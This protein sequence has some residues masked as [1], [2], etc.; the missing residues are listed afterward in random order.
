MAD[1]IQLQ[2]SASAANLYALVRNSAGD[3][4]NGA[5]FVT[6]A[7]ADLGSYDLPM[8]EQATSKFYAVA[9]PTVAAGV[10]AV[11]AY[12]RAGG[13]PAESDSCI[14]SGDVEWSGTAMI[15]T[16]SQASV[17]SIDGR[18]P[19]ALIG[20]RIDAT[21]DATGMEAG[22]IDAIMDDTIGDGTLT[23]RQALRVLVAGMAGKLSGAATSTVTIRNTADS[24]DVIVASVDADG[25]R[26]AVTVNV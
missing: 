16:A 15:V 13:A 18:I 3:I 11:T 24:V 2:H 19:A 14:A 9:F 22:A 8:T 10:Y 1:M 26:T 5:A 21:V 17:T 25:N 23:M 4:W 20:G 12:V 7:T 6:Y